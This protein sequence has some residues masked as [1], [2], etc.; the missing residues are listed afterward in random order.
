MVAASTSDGQL[1]G[2]DVAFSGVDVDLSVVGSAD[3]AV[4]GVTHPASTAST[5]IPL[6]TRPQRP[7]QIVAGNLPGR[8]RPRLARS[9]G[10]RAAKTT[11][12]IEKRATAPAKGRHPV[13]TP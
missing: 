7:L 13:V 2:A 11:G 8:P 6:T 4:G 3:G 1:G 12:S 10:A 9:G 5:S